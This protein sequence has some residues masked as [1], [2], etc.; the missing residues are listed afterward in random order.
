MSNMRLIENAKIVVGAVPIDT[1]GAAVTGDYVCMK[2]YTHLTIVIMQGAWA[3][4]TPAVTLKQA[5]DVS[6]S[7]SD[8]KALGF[9][10]Y[11][12]GTALTDDNLAA[13]AVVSDTYSLTATANL[14]N[15]IEVN[16]SSLDVDNGFDCVRLGIATPGS[17]ADLIA[18][19]YILTGARYPQAD[20]PSAIAN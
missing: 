15:V 1:T 12:V 8:E 20:P 4:G 3:G 5:T 11:F 19:L 14:F 17:N 6:N 9:T 16:A 18:V 13:V 10:K 2:G 7:L